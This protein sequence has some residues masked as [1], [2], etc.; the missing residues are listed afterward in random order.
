MSETKATVWAPEF[1]FDTFWST[2]C[3]VALAISRISLC[4][5]ESEWRCYFFLRLTCT[6]V[7]WA[8][9]WFGRR[10]SCSSFSLSKIQHWP[11]IK[12]PKKT[13]RTKLNKPHDF[14]RS[15]HIKCGRFLIF[16]SSIYP[17]SI[18]A[19][20]VALYWHMLFIS[21]DQRV[22]FDSI[23]FFFHLFCPHS[24]YPSNLICTQ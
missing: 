15:L 7:W 17:F 4:S 1:I 13:H 18:R 19:R 22:I 11:H 2:Q 24:H 14:D 21:Q 5:W 8:H 6:Y 3:S 12:L 16:F 20:T 10:S 23:P 9:I